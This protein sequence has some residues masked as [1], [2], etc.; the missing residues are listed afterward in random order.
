MKRSMIVELEFK[1][2]RIAK[3]AVPQQTRLDAITINMAINAHTAMI[4]VT[5]AGGLS[6]GLELTFKIDNF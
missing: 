6:A 2:R 5:L 4:Q 1:F 3:I